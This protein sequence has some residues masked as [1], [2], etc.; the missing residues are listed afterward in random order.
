MKRHFRPGEVQIEVHL[1]HGEPE[2]EGVVRLL[3]V[4]GAGQLPRHH[5]LGQRRGL[6]RRLYGKVNGISN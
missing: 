5:H 4:R 2:M 3:L 6:Q 1:Q